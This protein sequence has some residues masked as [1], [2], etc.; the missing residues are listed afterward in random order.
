VLRPDNIAVLE[1][2]A[3][4][5]TDDGAL[6]EVSHNALVDF[7]EDGFTKALR[8]ESPRQMLLRGAPRYESADPRYAWLNRL[9]CIAVGDIDASRAEAVQA[10]VYAVI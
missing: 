3:T 7:G 2:R 6:I 10:D 5:Q 9:Q 8:G 1:S 4:I